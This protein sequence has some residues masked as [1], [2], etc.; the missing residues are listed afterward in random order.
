MNKSIIK[1]VRCKREFW[2][3]HVH[4]KTTNK[5]VKTQSLESWI[6]AQKEKHIIDSL[7]SAA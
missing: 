2:S 5:S 4:K 3:I 7:T 6:P 1:S